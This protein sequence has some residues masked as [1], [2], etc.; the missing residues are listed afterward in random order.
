MDLCSVLVKTHLRRS[1]MPLFHSKR[2]EKGVSSCEEARFVAS[3]SFNLGSEPVED[4]QLLCL[5]SLS[6]SAL[7]RS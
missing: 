5:G 1:E 2:L 4:G 7:K 3:M 6:L